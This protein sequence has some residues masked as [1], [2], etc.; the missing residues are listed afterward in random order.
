[1]SIIL[2]LYGQNAIA[3]LPYRFCDVH[4]LDKL[5]DVKQNTYGSKFENESKDR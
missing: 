4:K 5:V 3:S 1:M 2:T